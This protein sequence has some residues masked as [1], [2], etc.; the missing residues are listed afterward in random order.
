MIQAQVQSSDALKNSPFALEASTV[1]EWSGNLR[2]NM[3]DTFVTQP[4]G[5]TMQTIVSP[6]VHI[7]YV[8]K[9][10]IA[11]VTLGNYSMFEVIKHMPIVS[12]KIGLDL[13]KSCLT[14]AFSW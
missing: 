10:E 14:F 9:S 12:C 8:P 4:E 6:S 5:P 11:S 2:L 3:I 1:Q 7:V 13:A